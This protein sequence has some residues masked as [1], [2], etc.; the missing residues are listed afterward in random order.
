MRAGI[1][2]DKG[3]TWHPA[4]ILSNPSPL[5]W[6]FWKSVWIGP[7]PGKH[8]LRVGAIDGKGRGEGWDPRGIFTEGARTQQTMQAKIS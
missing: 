5:T 4:S 3:K 7:R 2:F 8:G 6:A 1:S